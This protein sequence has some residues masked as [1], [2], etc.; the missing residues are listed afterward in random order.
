MCLK[1]IFLHDNVQVPMH[2]RETV[3]NDTR[4]KV[5][6]VWKECKNDQ[7]IPFSTMEA[8]YMQDRGRLSPKYKEVLEKIKQLLPEAYEAVIM[9]GCRFVPCTFF[10]F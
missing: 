9:K 2:E 4:H 3:L 1:K 5:M 8:K 10:S 6:D 7:V